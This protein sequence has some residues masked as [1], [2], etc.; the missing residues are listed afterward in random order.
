MHFL[1]I[2]DFVIASLV[3]LSLYLV[4]R[5]RRRG[6]N[7]DELHEF[8]EYANTPAER[9]LAA[10][11]AA[12]GIQAG[13]TVSG[14]LFAGL[15]AALLSGQRYG[16]D[17][18]III[19]LSWATLSLASGVI[20]IVFMATQI[21]VKNVVLD[22]SFAYYSILQLSALVGGLSRILILIFKI[23]TFKTIGVPQ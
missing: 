16:F 21:T 5:E 9:S 17:T 13:L 11:V 4:D 2:L 7:K 3:A 12:R 22:R 6:L 14:F 19:G 10:N 18:D 20:N 8:L 1:N 23:I 15:L